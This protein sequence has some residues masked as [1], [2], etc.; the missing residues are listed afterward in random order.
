MELKLT[1]EQLEEYLNKCDLEIKANKEAWLN[2]TRSYATYA[3]VR[4]ELENK[5]VKL[6]EV[7]GK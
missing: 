4:R 1:E 6:M 2:G 5:K 7:L 3:K